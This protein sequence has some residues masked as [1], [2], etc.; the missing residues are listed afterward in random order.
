MHWP[1]RL[2][3]QQPC[4]VMVLNKCKTAPPRTPG[5]MKVAVNV[6]TAMVVAMIAALNAPK[7]TTRVLKE[8]PPSILKRNRHLH[9]QRQY[10]IQTVM[11]L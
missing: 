11:L 2:L 10:Q 6:V 7:A 1:T 8:M 9:Q 4:V 3:W 5:A